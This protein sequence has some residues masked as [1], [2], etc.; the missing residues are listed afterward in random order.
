M[1]RTFAGEHGLT[2]WFSAST[3]R[4]D[5]QDD[6]NGIPH[7]LKTFIGEIAVV[8]TLAPEEDHLKL[9]LIKDHDKYRTED[10][11]LHLDSRTLLIR[12]E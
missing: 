1:L 8:I 9:Q 5:P 3:R 4:E 10:L 2:I 11:H 6:E 12:E 7:V